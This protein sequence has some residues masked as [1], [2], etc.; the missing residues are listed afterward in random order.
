MSIE[1]WPENWP[2]LDLFMQL[3]TQWHV[4]MNGATGLRYEALY[5]LLDRH[6]YTGD[7]WDDMFADIRTLERVALATM[8]AEAS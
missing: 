4:G 1:V 5:P 3:N 7:G 2:A 8:N 6:G